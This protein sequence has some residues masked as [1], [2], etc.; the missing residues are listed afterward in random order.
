MHCN[1]SPATRTEHFLHKLFPTS[2]CVNINFMYWSHIL[3]TDTSL[4]VVARGIFT[5]A[6]EIMLHPAFVYVFCLFIHKLMPILVRSSSLKFLPRCMEC[7][8]GLAMRFLSVRPSVKRVHCDKNGRKICPDFYTMRKI[9]QSS[10]MRRRMVGGGRPLLSEIL[11]QPA[12]V[13]AKS[14]ILNQ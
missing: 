6:K 1:C 13:G 10:F 2:K 11:G 5:F 3:A 8:R 9:I 4:P 7:R 12:R 14:P